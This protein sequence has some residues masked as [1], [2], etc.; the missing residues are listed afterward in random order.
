MRVLLMSGAVFFHFFLAAQK[1]FDH[2]LQLTETKFALESQ[3]HG[4]KW[5]FLRN[6]DTSAVGLNNKGFIHMYSVWKARPDTSSFILQWKPS[7]LWWSE[8][9]LFGLTTGPFFTQAKDS[10]VMATGY[11][12]TIWKRKTLQEPFK[13]VL[14]MGTQMRTPLPAATFEN[15]SVVKDKIAS[16]TTSKKLI[17]VTRPEGEARNLPFKTMAGAQ[18]LQKALNN[19]SLDHSLMLFSNQGRVMKNDLNKVGLLAFPYHFQSTGIKELSSNCFYE[20]GQFREAHYSKA[21]PVTGFYVHVWQVE[22]NKLRL[23]GAVH[24]FNQGP[25]YQ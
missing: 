20:W 12:F 22:N 6:M 25:S 2:E 13:F 4:I 11:F 17:A 9:G 21:D 16:G 5:G 18:S 14:D 1:R 8:D 10:A 15:D 23:L 7:A 24:Q 19:F 3:I